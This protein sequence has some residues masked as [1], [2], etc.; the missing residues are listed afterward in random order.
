MIKITYLLWVTSY[1]SALK[2]NG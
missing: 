2:K 1:E